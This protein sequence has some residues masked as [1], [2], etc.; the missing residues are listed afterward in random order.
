M[1]VHGLD[2]RE[3]AAGVARKK[4]PTEAT[5]YVRMSTH[6]DEGIERQERECL[7]L[8]EREGWMVREVIRDNKASAVKAK[9]R[10]GFERL[11]ES[12]PELIVMW[13]VDRLVRKGTDLER[14]IELGVPVHSVK[15]GPMDLATASGRV[16]AR[17]LVTVATFEGELR[18]E[19]QQ[20]AFRYMASKG[21]PW[22]AHRPMGFELPVEVAKDQWTVE[23]RESEAEIVRQMYADALNGVALNRI[24]TSLNERGIRG[25]TGKPWN[26]TTVKALLLA[27]RNIGVRTRNG[28]VVMRDA[29]PSLV[30][31]DVFTRVKSILTNPARKPG[32]DGPR[33][34]LLSS[35]ATCHEC[36]NRIK[37]S[38]RSRNIRV[39]G[40]ITKG[41][42]GR[43]LTERVRTYVCPDHHTEAGVKV[44]GCSSADAEWLEGYVLRKAIGKLSTVDAADWTGERQEV[45]DAKALNRELQAMDDNLKAAGT[46]LA[47]GVL[48]LSTVVAQTEAAR[49]RRSEIEDQLQRAAIESAEVVDVEAVYEKLMSSDEAEVRT[50]LQRVLRS[51]EIR[52]RGKG[53]HGHRSTDVILTFMDGAVDDG[54]DPNQSE[55]DQK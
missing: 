2:H 50:N 32:G 46:A 41:D 18:T 55:R 37:G 45:V 24:A 1:A 36:G 12:D 6:K 7:D 49:R 5:V 28:E 27:E 22:W 48:E 25:G 11:I 33:K 16:N 23:V 54:T 14:L 30:P 34:Y 35:W 31:F 53:R 21:R 47:A 17:L 26:T 9:K 3:D 10:P 19:R 40:K 29:W 15:A 8:C 43:N 38:A 4:K 51:V 20:T 52:R 13:S 44:A 39:D 42:D